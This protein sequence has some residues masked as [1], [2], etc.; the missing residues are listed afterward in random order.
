MKIVTWNVNSVRSRLER[1][2]AFLARHQP[3]VVCLQELK[4][5]QDD[6]PTDAIAD[7]GYHAAV[8]GQKT[9][10]GVAILSRKK[11]TSIARGFGDDDPQARF[12]TGKLGKL[13]IASA[14]IPNGR[15]VGCEHWAYKLRWLA[16]LRDWLDEVAKPTERV[17]VC[18]DFNVAR[19]DLDAANPETWRDTVLAHADGRAALQALLDWPLADVFRTHHPDGGVFTWWDYR[20]L[21]F[22]K[23]NGLRIDYHLATPPLAT[24]CTD[25][26]VDREERK[27]EKPSD[28]APVIATFDL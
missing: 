25:A 20:R 8:Y 5:V 3:D 11:L 16:K 4:C 15:E 1:L 24:L 10:N 12:I 27:G 28:H 14:Y 22:P 21:A 17:V 18:G 2:L 13:R 26:Q 19:D 9:Y 6:F 23:N 7:A